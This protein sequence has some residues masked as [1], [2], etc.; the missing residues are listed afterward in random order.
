M[1]ELSTFKVIQPDIV[2]SGNEVFHLNPRTLKY[3]KSREGSFADRSAKSWHVNYP[4][5]QGYWNTVPFRTAA[6]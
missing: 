6:T 4:F 3:E 1:N 5:S 2:K